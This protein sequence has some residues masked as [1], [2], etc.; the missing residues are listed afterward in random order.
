MSNCFIY[1]VE[2]NKALLFPV[3]S[4]Q[5]F[6]QFYLFPWQNMMPCIDGCDHGERGLTA[7]VLT[8]LYVVPLGSCSSFQNN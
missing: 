1:Y 8:F 7:Q 2:M 5:H 3:L 4:V 6:D